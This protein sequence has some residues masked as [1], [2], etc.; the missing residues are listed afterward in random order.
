MRD[1]ARQGQIRMAQQQ[2][3]Q[4]RAGGGANGLNIA[5]GPSG[6]SGLGNVSGMM[7]TGMMDGAQGRAGMSPQQQLQ[8]QRLHMQQMQQVGAALGLTVGAVLGL[9]TE[10]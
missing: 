4:M 9:T 5:G 1:R 6:A 3:A 8:Q 10:P 7:G 2:Q